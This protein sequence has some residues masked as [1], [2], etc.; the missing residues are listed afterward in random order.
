MKYLIII[1]FL[2]LLLGC[3]KSLGTAPDGEMDIVLPSTYIEWE[4][5]HPQDTTWW[6]FCANG[7]CMAAYKVKISGVSNP[8]PWEPMCLEYE[9]GKCVPYIQANGDTMGD[10]GM[11]HQQYIAHYDSLTAGWLPIKYYEGTWGEDMGIITIN[12]NQCVPGQFLNCTCDMTNPT[13][14]T[15]GWA[16]IYWSF[17]FW[18]TDSLFGF[19]CDENGDRIKLQHSSYDLTLSRWHGKD[20]FDIMNPIFRER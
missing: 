16:P 6:T 3:D 15:T 11:T 20:L 13:Y 7:V 18:N 14:I 17:S 5:I 1:P 19:Q 12:V 4:S 9:N 8:P 10:D 2:L